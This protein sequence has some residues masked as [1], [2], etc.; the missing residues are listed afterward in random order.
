MLW[1][2][3]LD[4]NEKLNNIQSAGLEKPAVRVSTQQRS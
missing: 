3:M 2:G 4:I 1:K